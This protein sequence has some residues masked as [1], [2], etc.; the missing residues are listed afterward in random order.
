MRRRAWHYLRIL[1]TKALE[2]IGTES[3]TFKPAHNTALLKNLP[4]SAWELYQTE[5]KAVLPEHGFTESKYSIVQSELA[6]ILQSLLDPQHP[7]LMD[8]TS[9]VDFH[10][11]RIHESRTQQE[12]A[13]IT[14]TYLRDLDVTDPIQ[15]I[16]LMTTE[17]FF[18]KTFLVV[19]QA[20]LR[21]PTDTAQTSQDS[22]DK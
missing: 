22:R 20:L 8:V 2:S 11:S 16:V 6:S 21:L 9:Y 19:H 4:D 18:S 3:E 13:R 5:Q 14:Q 17:L 15:S 7:L 1:G 12:K 10:E